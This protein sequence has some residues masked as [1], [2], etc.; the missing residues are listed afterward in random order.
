MDFLLEKDLAQW[1][2][3]LI[4]QI[5]KKKNTKRLLS[6]MIMHSTEQGWR[7]HTRMEATK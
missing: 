4:D 5:L 2:E 6:R 7:S 3:T 1:E